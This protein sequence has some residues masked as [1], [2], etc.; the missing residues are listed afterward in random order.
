[1]GAIIIKSSRDDG[2]VKETTNRPVGQ[3]MALH[4]INVSPGSI[5]LTETTCKRM[6]NGSLGAEFKVLGHSRGRLEFLCGGADRT[7]RRRKSSASLP[8]PA[9][10]FSWKSEMA[11]DSGRI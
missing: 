6:E 7:K 9:V 3:K 8:L 1:M 2:V 4:L 11:A 10:L 5:E